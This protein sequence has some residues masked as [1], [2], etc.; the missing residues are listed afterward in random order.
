MKENAEREASSEILR[1][2]QL[3]DRDVLLSA[4]L[5]SEQMLNGLIDR[6]SQ[7]DHRKPEE[8]KKKQKYKAN[9]KKRRYRS[10]QIC[11]KV[12]KLIWVGRDDK[13][14]QY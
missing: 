11:K 4:S 13:T 5:Y 7:S 1:D 2:T 3:S 14:V 12:A 8:D 10:S 9:T 6:S